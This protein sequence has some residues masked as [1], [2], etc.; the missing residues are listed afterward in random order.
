MFVSALTHSN[1]KLLLRMSSVSQASSD[2]FQADVQETGDLSGDNNGNV[3]HPIPAS[4]EEENEL[5]VAAENS[6]KLV[7]KLLAAHASAE[8]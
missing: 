7:T 4:A 3:L 5:P 6:T 2:P 1:D 8:K